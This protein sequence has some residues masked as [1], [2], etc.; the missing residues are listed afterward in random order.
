MEIGCKVVLDEHIEN[1]DE[2]KYEWLWDGRKDIWEIIALIRTFSGALNDVK[3]G[4]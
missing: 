4:L 2:L 1:D 3:N